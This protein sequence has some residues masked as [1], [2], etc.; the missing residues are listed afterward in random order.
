MKYVFGLFDDA[1]QAAIAESKVKGLATIERLSGHHGDAYSKLRGYGLSGHDLD[2]FSEGVRRGG[3]LICAKCDDANASKVADMF[4]GLPSVDVSRRAERWR[5]AGWK[6]YDQSAGMYAREDIDRERTLGQSELH[7]PI[8]Q[9]QIA[10]GKRE[11]DRGGVRV[12]THVTEQPFE[13][14]VA[15]R[16]EQVRVERHPV[17]RAVTAADEIGDRTIEMTARGEEAVVQKS[18]RVVEEVVVSKEAA[19]RQETIRDTVKKT[20]VDVRP[21]ATEKRVSRPSIDTDRTSRTSAI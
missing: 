9:E 3:T 21:V 12:E 11:V 18:A 19:T 6:G 15:L 4:R 17:N 20:D 14:T 8:I 5:S 10:V 1:G 2:G 7:V 13:Q 16:E